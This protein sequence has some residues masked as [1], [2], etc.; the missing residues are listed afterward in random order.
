LGWLSLVLNFNELYYALPFI[1]FI[2]PGANALQNYIK[3]TCKFPGLTTKNKVDN[4]CM[5]SNR[6]I[7][8]TEAIY[9]LC[10]FWF[11]V[12]IFKRYVT[13]LVDVSYSEHRL[14][15]LHLYT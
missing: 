14:F 9:C 4:V 8:L 1:C 2:S 13:A 11:G 15:L 10:E 12:E 6:V 3:P 5:F 7:S